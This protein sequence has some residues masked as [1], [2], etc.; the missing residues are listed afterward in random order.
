MNQQ[1]Q[2][3]DDQQLVDLIARALG[4]GN[5]DISVFTQ[6]SILSDGP[7]PR[8]LPGMTLEEHY[9]ANGHYAKFWKDNLRGKWTCAEAYQLFSVSP[10][11]ENSIFKVLEEDGV[12]ELQH[13]IIA[14]GS[15]RK[16][17]RDEIAEFLGCDALDSRVADAILVLIH[18]Y[19]F[20]LPVLQFNIKELKSS[21]DCL[22]RDIV[23]IAHK[24]HI[25]CHQTDDDDDD[26]YKPG[27]CKLAQK[28]R[29][30]RV[31]CRAFPQTKHLPNQLKE[32]VCYYFHRRGFLDT[33]DGT[34]IGEREFSLDVQTNFGLVYP[35]RLAQ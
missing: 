21:A 28:F 4:M 14:I 9:E 22:L 15:G 16:T 35:C 18:E 11:A 12:S 3:H 6:P 20:Q 27:T 34:S 31:Y 7:T 13:I 2:V 23:Y 26:D 32:I 10:A 5:D 1:Q 17:S 24:F 8:P 29:G 25:K 33:V 30:V 19:F